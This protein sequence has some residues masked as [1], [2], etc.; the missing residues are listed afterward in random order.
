MDKL[1]NC[2]EISTKKERERIQN[3][4]RESVEKLNKDGVVFGLS[5]G[6]DSS[7]LAYLAK[8]SFPENSFALI[9]P[10]RD[11]DEKDTRDAEELAERLSLD[12]EKVDITP[13]LE[14]IGTYELVPEWFKKSF[15]IKFGINILRFLTARKVLHSLKFGELLRKIKELRPGFAFGMSKIRLRM[16]MIHKYGFL[17]NYAV[18]G[19]TNKTEYLLGH[20]DIYGDGA[21][22]IECLLH[23]YKTQVR[24][25]SRFL[26]IEE[27]ILKKPPS[28][29]LVP[30][31]T[32]EEAMGMTFEKVDRILVFIEKGMEESES[33]KFGFSEK[34]ITEVK[35]AIS[36]TDLRRTLP[37]DLLKE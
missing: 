19:A 30:G 1:D 13:A 37:F 17:K 29:N 28:A 31:F 22:D 27:K 5:G 3:F 7:L 10:E 24:Q 4:I 23:L 36:N 25:L 14:E 32:D 6:I 21:V 20:Y 35:K 18:L 15:S 12:Y 16:I 33:R 2:L 26:G 9:L 34:E 11:S 8:E